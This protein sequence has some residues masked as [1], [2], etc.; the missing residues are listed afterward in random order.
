MR[1]I[2]VWQMLLRAAAA[3]VLLTAHGAAFASLARILGDDGPKK[4]GR[5][6]L[7]PVAQVPIWAILAAV[8]GRAGW[9][10]PV[11]VDPA[12]LRGGRAGL[13]V[14]VAG[15]LAAMLALGVLAWALRPLVLGT[16][17]PGLSAGLNSWLLT[18]SEL[19]AWIAL[20]GL[21]PIPPLPGGYLLLAVWPQGYHAIA[22]RNQIVGVALVALF[23]LLQSSGVADVLRPLVRLLS[24][25]VS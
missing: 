11:D 16:F 17:S 18:T 15:A 21:L 19:A 6:T 4:D 8:L 25:A 13:L 10:K 23:W 3:F 12:E 7:N 22:R 20:L 5:V 9:V 2:S 14:C 1:D 24:P